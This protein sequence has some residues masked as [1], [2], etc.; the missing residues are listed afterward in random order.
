VDKPAKVAPHTVMRKL[1]VLMNHI[2][3]NPTFV[4][5]LNTIAP[6]LLKMAGAFGEAIARSPLPSD[7]RGWPKAGE[8]FWSVIFTREREINSALRN[9][10]GIT[11]R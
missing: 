2:L 9:R 8:G 11:I 5:Q 3:K 6:D 7:G 1:I 10:Y 4:L